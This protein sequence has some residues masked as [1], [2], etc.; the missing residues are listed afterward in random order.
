MQLRLTTK[1]FEQASAQFRELARRAGNWRPVLAQFGIHML[2]SVEQTFHA[3]GRP[4]LW[5]PSIRAMT[6]GGKTLI[7]TARLKNSMVAAVTGPTTL[8][9]GTNVRYAAVHQFGFSGTVQIPEHL[10]RVR[11]RDIRGSEI[12]VSPKTGKRYKAHPKIARGFAVVKA[13]AA[14]LRI[15]ARPFLVV[16]DAD[17]RMW[18]RLAEKYLEGMQ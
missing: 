18:V 7:D 8:R 3:G 10:R 6:K 9:V 1:N 16:Q 12:R 15:P 4:T 5:P 13:H 17:D 14:H 11:S 2:R